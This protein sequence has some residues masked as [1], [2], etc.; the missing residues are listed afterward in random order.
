MDIVALGREISA[1]Q[2]ALDDLKNKAMHAAWQISQAVLVLRQM[3]EGMR[4]HKH[5][6]YSW[7]GYYERCK[8]GAL[9]GDRTDL[10]TGQRYVS[11][12]EWPEG[13]A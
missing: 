10:D 5:A 9:S 2:V 8:C 3:E 1:V 11:F 4:E 6:P 7:D 13:E 12:S